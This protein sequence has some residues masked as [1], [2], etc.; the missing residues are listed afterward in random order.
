VMFVSNIVMLLVKHT[1]TGQWPD[2]TPQWWLGL[3]TLETPY[4]MSIVLLPIAAFLCACPALFTI[5]QC[6]SAPVLLFAALGTQ[7]AIRGLGQTIDD[8]SAFSSLLLTDLPLLR[9][10]ADGVIGFA[11]GG[12]WVATSHRARLTLALGVTTFTAGS[13]ATLASIPVVGGTAATVLHFIIILSVGAGLDRST[14]CRRTL[15]ILPLIGSYGL[16]SFLV[17]RV[18]IQALVRL[19]A[20]SSEFRY[21][22]ALTGGLAIMAALCVLRRQ[23]SGWD[24]TLRRIYL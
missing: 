13:V 20:V 21:L 14:L 4:S 16:F 8:H 24:H 19:P 3:L 17:H 23:H 10:V 15:W 6:V 7:V 9:L 18:A 2:L 12:L 11:L 1:V 22:V 5:R